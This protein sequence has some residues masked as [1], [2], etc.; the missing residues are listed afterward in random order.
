VLRSCRLQL[1]EDLASVSRALRIRRAYLQAIE[2]GRAND[3]PGAAYAAGFVRAYAQYLGLD[4]DEVVRRF[5]AESSAAKKGPALQFPL[6]ASEGGMPKGA[7]LLIGA[8]LALLAYAAWYL[9]TSHNDL[10]AEIVSPI[11]E[12]LDRLLTLGEQ[13]LLW[14]EKETVGLDRPVENRSP[15]P[16]V[17]APRA[18]ALPA[19]P[20][21][22]AVASADQPSLSDAGEQSRMAGAEADTDFVTNA[23]S[24]GQ[25]QQPQGASPSPSAQPSEIGSG[26]VS[27]A[28]SPALGADALAAEPP[29]RN[30]EAVPTGVVFG[31]DEDVRIVVK[32]KADS[33]IQ[34]RDEIGNRVLL[35]RLMKPG[36]VF[37]VP[38]RAGLTMVT[39]NAGALEVI[40]DGNPAPSLGGDGVVRR[41][42]VLAVEALRSGGVARN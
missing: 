26:V 38:D 8:A 20:E 16:P 27:R 28:T 25:L 17:E 34:V 5:K 9:K 42:V 13:A 18:P 4:G 32:A 12:E 33:W 41:G 23:G 21:P 29:A 35:S 37:R 1:G 14:R 36:D 30:A 31:S 2:E 6:P 24:Q 39:G 7:A 10:V 11:P 22:S 19:S 40:I 3:L 15:G